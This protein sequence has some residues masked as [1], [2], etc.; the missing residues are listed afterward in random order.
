MSDWPGNRVRSM[1]VSNVAWISPEVLTWVPAGIV[2][3][4][5]SLPRET[6]RMAVAACWPIGV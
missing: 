6:R 1:S 5:S 2:K 4:A 3:I